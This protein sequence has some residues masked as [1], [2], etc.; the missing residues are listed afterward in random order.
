M[1]TK[2]FILAACRPRSAVWLC[3]TVELALKSFVATP[4]FAAQPREGK[5]IPTVRRASP[6][7]A[8]G[9]PQRKHS[10]N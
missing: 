3:Q 1:H 10:F 4:L 6:H 5:N 9:K 7:C 8:G 2:Q